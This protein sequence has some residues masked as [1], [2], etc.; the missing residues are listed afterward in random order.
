MNVNDEY[1]SFL[2]RKMN[3]MTPIIKIDTLIT[4]LNDGIHAV[5]N[6]CGLSPLDCE[7]ICNELQKYIDDLSIDKKLS[8]SSAKVEVAINVIY[9]IDGIE[10]KM[11][12]NRWKLIRHGM[13]RTIFNNLG[14]CC[15]EM[16][17]EEAEK[18][19]KDIEMQL[20]GIPEW[21]VDMLYNITNGNSAK[22]VNPHITD[23]F[24][25]QSD[26]ENGLCDWYRKGVK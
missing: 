26:L 5:K 8:G 19:R 22:N 14:M 18:K 23:I 11:C 24:K 1:G 12:R 13:V 7:Y 9:D 3:K 6:K 25:Q 10:T 20:T 2:N 17:R 16:K 15:T 21:A 4:I